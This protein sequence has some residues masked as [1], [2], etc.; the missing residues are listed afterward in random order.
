MPSRNSVH[1]RRRGE[2]LSDSLHGL[3][4][5][6]SSPQARGTHRL[7]TFRGASG[8]FIPAGAGNTRSS[9]ASY[10]CR[11]VHPRRRGEH[12][13]FV[14]AEAYASGSSPQARGTH[15][16]WGVEP[17][18]ARFIP[19]GAGNT[20]RVEIGRNRRTVHPRRRGEHKLTSTE[21]IILT[22][23]SPQARGTR[24]VATPTHALTRFIPAGAGNTV[25]ARVW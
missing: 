20:Q 15:D 13:T 16:V 2:H 25:Y 1:P 14:G 19:A 6:G 18:P 3:T 24:P 12:I 11:P 8:R 9:T 5:S 22:G 23:S 4:V 10:L 21:T 7:A 17:R